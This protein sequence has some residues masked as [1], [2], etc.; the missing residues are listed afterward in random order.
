MRLFFLFL[1]GLFKFFVVFAKFTFIHY[2]DEK[3]NYSYYFPTTLLEN[4]IN[5][6]KID[7]CHIFLI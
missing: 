3:K 5:S 6:D 2:F 7:L 1:K 4:E